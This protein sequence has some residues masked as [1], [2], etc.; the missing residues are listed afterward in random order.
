MSNV[1]FH[2]KYGGNGGGNGI[3][4]SNGDS[5]VEEE[6]EHWRR[7][8]EIGRLVDEKSYATILPRSFEEYAVR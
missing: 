7:A 1:R 4:S 3:V 8:S 6:E 5:A 2:S